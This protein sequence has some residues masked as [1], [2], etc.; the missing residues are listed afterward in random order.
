MSYLDVPRLHFS[1]WFQADVSTI[2]ND[3]RTFQN[4][5]FVPE[6]QQLNQNGSWNPEGT[7]VY[8]FVDCVVSGGVLDG[9]A[10]SD[11]S[12]DPAIGMRVE[13]ADRRAPGKLVDLDPQQQMV[14]EIW[15]MQVRLLDAAR[16]EALCGEYVPGPFC[17]LW[18]RQQT[19]VPRDQQ[20]AANY[21]SVLDATAWAD[22][23]DSPLLRALRDRSDDGMLSICFNVYGYGRDSTI[24]RY[25][26]GHLVGSIGPYRRAEPKHYVFGRQMI[27]D[28][29][30]SLMVPA[31]GVYNVQGRF[32]TEACRLTLDLGNTFPIEDANSGLMDIGQVLVG[33]L[34]DN[35]Q[36]T[37]ASVHA[38]QVAIVGEVPY[39]N[40]DWYG[41][42]AGVQDFDLRGQREAMALLP[43]HP[44]VLL[45]PVPA[46]TTFKVLL[47]ETVDGL[48]LRADQFV[49]RLDPGETGLL[50]L[51]AS[52]FGRP[53]AEADI[54]LTP[55][56]GLMGGSGG[57]ATMSP[58]TR[59]DAAIPDIA[60]PADAFAFPGRVRTDG[61][62][63]AAATLR[64][65]DD[66]PGTPRGYIAG[67]LYGVAYRLDRQPP[68]YLSNP[69]NYVSV[70]AFS[71]KTVPDSPTWY[72]DIQPVFAQ[73]GN[74]Y[75]IMS[76]YVVDLNDYASVCTRLKALH[77]AFSLPR[78]DS[79]HMPVTRDLGRG[80]RDTILKWLSTPDV[81][82][83]PRLGRPAMASTAVASGGASEAAPQVP[84][85]S[86]PA[87]PD[88]GLLPEQGGG[89]TAFLLQFERRRRG[90]TP[91][92]DAP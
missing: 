28:T 31:G 71:G 38:S 43:E 86:A 23:L 81:D 76:R 67:Q 78:R 9:L 29:S 10:L 6:Y 54:A 46:S 3:V 63:Y 34:R 24:P 1:G 66:G 60:T 62:G 17:N 57:G 68:G 32:D 45:S 40:P 77:L 58:P 33:V 85:A 72:D 15:G 91:S 4:A 26:M 8:R 18:K 88:L 44:L 47:Q 59:P 27:A 16:R 51:R 50:E 80:D 41:Q 39:R 14:S 48:Y 75:P 87:Q 36:A 5:S 53:L 82:G 55:T 79:N 69:L 64:M 35:P 90:A 73:Y 89:K 21:Q 83:L 7:G 22:E 84:A 2:N 13:N 25:T 52:R 12:Q 37:M 20:L 70:L 61:D 92:G 49:F 30:A 65:S 42:T 11:P 19:G 56:Q 74:L